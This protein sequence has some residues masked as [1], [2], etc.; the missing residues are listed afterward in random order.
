MR[1]WRTSKAVQQPRGWFYRESSIVTEWTRII[2]GSNFGAIRGKVQGRSLPL[3]NR[4]I[5]FPDMRRPA[6]S[7]TK[8]W[9]MMIVEFE[10]RPRMVK[11]PNMTIARWISSGPIIEQLMV[12]VKSLLLLPFSHHF[13]PYSFLFALYFSSYSHFISW[14]KKISYSHFLMILSFSQDQRDVGTWYGPEENLEGGE[15]TR[16]SAKGSEVK[17][18]Q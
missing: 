8:W 15:G 4:T 10:S 18:V 3:L 14:D 7:S 11:N 17:S 2:N 16:S 1:Q 13:C 12:I 9:L 5:Q 6:P